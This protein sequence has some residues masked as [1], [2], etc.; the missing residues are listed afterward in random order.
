[1]RKRTK[2][3]WMENEHGNLNWSFTQT[4]M[5]FLQQNDLNVISFND[6]VNDS[7]NG[8]QNTIITSPTAHSTFD[9]PVCVRSNRIRSNSQTIWS[10][11]DNEEKK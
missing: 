7:V 2:A 9:S 5:L 11:K 8:N 3:V 4:G 10:E 6:S 1:M